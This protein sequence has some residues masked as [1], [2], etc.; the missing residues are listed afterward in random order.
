MSRNLVSWHTCLQLTWSPVECSN[1]VFLIILSIFELFCSPRPNSFETCCSHHIRNVLLF[2]LKKL[3]FSVWTLNI[4]SL[5]CF[6]LAIGWKGFANQCIW[7]LFTF[8]TTSQLQRRWGCSWSCRLDFTWYFLSGIY[9]IY[10]VAASHSL[11]IN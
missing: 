3:S 4:L 1:L 10:L 11:L 8:Y 5:Y 9:L 2:A 6:Q 7:F